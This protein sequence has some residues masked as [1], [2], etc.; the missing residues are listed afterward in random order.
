MRLDA[1]LIKGLGEGTDSIVGV[2]AGK[3]LDLL[4]GTAIRLDTCE[5]SH[6]DDERG[7]RC[8][9]L[10]PWR[11]LAQDRKSTRLN[12]SHATISYALFCL[13]KKTNPTHEYTSPAQSGE[14]NC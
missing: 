9:L 11:I 10:S 14:L 5:A 3:E 13:K 4:E 7:D 8:E 6:L 12:S 1:G 2:L